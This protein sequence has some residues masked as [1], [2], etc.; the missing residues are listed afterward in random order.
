MMV[1]LS[2]EYSILSR[3]FH[4]SCLTHIESTYYAGQTCGNI[5]AFPDTVHF[6]GLESLRVSTAAD[7]SVANTE[8]TQSLSPRDPPRHF[9]PTLKPFVSPCRSRLSPH[10][11]GLAR[12]RGLDLLTPK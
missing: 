1:F 3:T 6:I 5:A 10:V 9:R 7:L 2:T 11:I 4:G 12:G 8:G